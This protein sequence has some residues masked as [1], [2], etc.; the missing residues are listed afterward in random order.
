MHEH[1]PTNLLSLARA[2][3]ML[4]VHRQT[5]SHWIARGELRVVHIGGRVRVPYAEIQ[6]LLK[7][8]ARSNE[9]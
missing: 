5:L 9:I 8:E 2:A 3:R 1:Q 7:A 4:G 6:R